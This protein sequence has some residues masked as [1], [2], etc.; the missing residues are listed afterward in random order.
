MALHDP[1]TGLPN[2][3]FF[4]RR[5]ESASRQATLNDDGLFAVLFLDIDRFKVVNDSLGHIV[6]DQLLVHIARRLRTL[7]RP[8]DVVARLG[9]DEFAI[10]LEDLS[11]ES[12]ATQIA[13]RLQKE[14][15]QP[16]IVGDQEVFTAASIGITF[17]TGDQET[18]VDLIRN[19]DTAMYRAKSLG[20]AR[21][22][23]FD[24]G[25]HLYAVE[26]LQLETDLRR[27]LDREEFLLYY[28]PIVSLDS[29]QVT[30]CEALIRW[31]HPERGMVL[32]GEFIPVAEDTGL[33]GPMSDWVLRTA[34]EQ[35]KTW[36]KA[37]LRIPISVNISPR[38]IKQADLHEVIAAVLLETGLDP[39]LLRIELT[40]SAL[41]ENADSAAKPLY[42][43]YAEGVK[44]S[45]D[46]FGTG[47]SS[48]TY[49]RRFPISTLKIDESFTREI[50]TDPSDAA[51][52]PSVG[53]RKP[54][55]RQNSCAS[56][57]FM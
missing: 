28:Q 4:M 38:H 54:V 57:Q 46:D 5:L 1:L 10:L 32:P 24:R 35:A 29:L 27:A 14:F 44:I 2:R 15:S 41:M 17:G 20:R 8:E 31:R 49:L 45:L 56:D 23:K 22:E 48:L 52:S 11:S 13:D 36:E 47:Y 21:Y 25:M 37:G 42:R 34:C 26:L 16:F 30:G 3:T 55:F 18:P 33:I 50:A 40:E 7:V 53:R 12:L 51:H 9:G 43:L 19:A 39:R 6:G